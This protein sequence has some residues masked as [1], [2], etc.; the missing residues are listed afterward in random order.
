M[1]HRRRP[2]HRCSTRCSPAAARAATSSR[3]WRWATSSRERGWRVSFAGTAH[4]LEARL[5]PERGIPFHRAAGAAGGRPRARSARRAALATLAAS[6]LAARAAGARDSAW[7]SCSAPA[8]TSR[9]RPCS[10]RGWPAGRSCCSSP[11]PGPAPPTAGSRASPPARGGRAIRRRR[12]DLRCPAWVTGV[13]VRAAF[14]DVPARAAA[15]GPAARCWCSAAARARSSSTRL[16]PEAAARL[17]ESCRRSRS[18]TRPASATSSD[19]RA[20]YARGR[21]RRS[22][23]EVVPFLD[24][25]AGA[26]A[27]ATCSSRAP[28]PSPSPRSAPPAG[29]SVLLPLVDRRRRTRW[30]TPRLLAEAGRRASCSRRRATAERLAATARR[31]ARRSGSAAR[32]GRA[33]PARWPGP[34][35]RGHRRPRAG[36]GGGDAASDAWE[37]RPL[38]FQPLRRPARVHFVGIG[39]A[40]M[41]GIAEV[42]LDYERCEVTGCDQSRRRGDRAPRASWASTIR[43]GHSRR[44]PRRRRAGGA[45]R[46]RWPRTTRRSARRGGAAS[47]WCGGPRCSAELMRLQVRHRR[48]R[49]PRQDHHHF[50]G[51]HDA[52]RGRARPDG[53][54]RRPAAR[55]R[56]PARASAR[57]S[58]WW[59]RPTSSTA[60]SCA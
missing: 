16:M 28:A 52:H 50:A 54:R 26:M 13:P 24:D 47:R 40:G 17:L 59:P 1:A 23:V 27:A 4:G 56:A 39:G 36:R 25:V 32:D 14:F 42:L 49:H 35:P 33:R 29:P 55:S 21:R 9:R 37:R 60:A 15:G 46:R 22:H 34:A 7:T 41:S 12:D 18:S 11:T 5:V 53:D 20:A 45:S 44:P 57:A 51:R 6:A 31:A 38:M 48:R 19:A 43:H 30:T 2:R 8:A 3:R 10:A 58:T